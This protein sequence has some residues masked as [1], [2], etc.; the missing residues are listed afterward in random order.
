MICGHLAAEGVSANLEKSEA[1][2]ILRD[3]NQPTLTEF[4][5][6]D[7]QCSEIGYRA[8]DAYTSTESSTK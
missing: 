2:H 1:L 5:E 8:H 4:V 3:I 6:Y 7:L